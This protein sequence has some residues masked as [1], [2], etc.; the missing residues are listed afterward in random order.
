MR[1]TIREQVTD[2]ANL[3]TGTFS[4]KNIVN[5]LGLDKH[6]VVRQMQMLKNAGV[7]VKVGA[8]RQ[9]M[10]LL[11]KKAP[12]VLQVK[13]KDAAKEL[14]RKARQMKVLKGMQKGVTYSSRTL[15]DETLKDISFGELMQMAHAGLIEHAEKNKSHYWVRRK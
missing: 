11:A 7:I 8:A 4:Y 15:R 13:A 5:D 14:A 9:G 6:E 2:Y 3:S 10:Y 12:K 1:R